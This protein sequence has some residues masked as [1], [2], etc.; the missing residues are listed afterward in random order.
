[1][2]EEKGILIRNI[3]YMLSYAFQE[4]KKNN[5]EPIAEEDFEH[6]Q[7]LFAEILFKGMSMQLKQGLY[8]EY[9]ERTDTLPV[10]RGKIDLKGTIKNKLQRKNKI[11]CEFDELTENNIFNQIIITTADLLIR[12]KGVSHKRKIQLKSL[13]PFF[14]NIDHI[15][16]AVI[17]WNMLRYQRNNHSYR[18]LMNICYFII[19]GLL[20]SSESGSYNMPTFSDE[21]MNL[22]YQRFILEY[23]KQEHKE[24]KTSADRI[25][26]NLDDS[27]TSIIEMLPS[28]QSDITLRKGD[29][30]LIIDAKYYG[31]M[32]QTYYDKET[33]HSGNLYQIF[34]YVKNEDALNTGNV[35][36]LLLYAKSNTTDVPNLDA[37]FGPN[38][39]MAKALDLSTNFVEIKKQ[40]DEI[41]N[42]I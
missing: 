41:V 40:L 4:L 3:Y 37:Y 7:D 26:W 39:I 27:K 17:R 10:L 19:D 11:S 31:R 8:K 23:Y 15:D 21:H 38:H 25:D 24:L 29:K 20:L 9:V 36:G 12:T 42:L 6:I 18:M 14:S 35:S 2:T 34:T 30:T 28:M 16:P 33:I 5:Y 22:L 1:M 13:T 32:L